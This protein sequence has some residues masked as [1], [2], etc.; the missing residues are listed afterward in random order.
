MRIKIYVLCIWVFAMPA[1][2]HAQNNSYQFSHLDITNGL[3]DNQVNCIYKDEKGFMW[4][5]TTSGLNRYDGSKFKVFKRDIKDPN[6]LA[7][8]HVMR[9]AEGPGKK[10]W[11]FTHSDISIY[12]PTVERF[13]NNIAA[14]LS[15]YKIPANPIT[16]I[17]KDKQGEFWFATDKKGLYRYS[18]KT[19]QTAFYNNSGNSPAALHSNH[20]IDIVASQPNC[21]WLI[22]NDG[23]IEQ[24]DSKVNKVLK[25]YD[26]LAKALDT[27][28]RNFIMIMD[29]KQNLWVCSD[30]G[31]IGVYCYKTL[32]NKLVHY[33]KDTPEGR[34][35]SNVITSIIQTDDDKIWVGSDH[36]GINVIDPITNKVYYILSRA[37]DAKS[38]SGNSVYLYKDNTG[39]IWAGTFKQGLNYYHRGIMQFPLYKHLTTDPKSLPCEDINSFE[40]DEKQNLWIGTNGNGLIYFNRSTN[41]YTQFKHD[42]SNPNSITSDIIVRL[43]IDK[44]KRLWIGTYFGGLD[45]YDGKT[46][47]HYRHNKKDPGSLTDDRIYTIME[48]A[49][50][51]L[52]VGTF[53]GGFNVFDPKTNSFRHP[54]Y[55]SN[56]E[57]T[58]VIYEDRQQNKW[59]GRDRGIDVILKGSN[60][61]RHYLSEPKNVNSLVGNDVNTITQDKKGLIWIGTKDGLS[62]LNTKTN[63]FLNIEEGVNLPANNVSNIIEDNAGRMWVSTTNGLASIILTEAEGK[64]KVE[65]SNYNELDGL[66]GRA[67]NL[68]AAKRLKSGELVFGG[69]HGFNLF[70]PMVLNTFKP[71]PSLVFTD[72]NLFNKSVAVGDTLNGKVILTKALSETKEITLQHNQNVFDI[73]FAAFDYF[74]PNKIKFE[75]KLEGFDKGWI[76]V[77]GN[78]RKATYTNLDGGDYTFKVR[79]QGT[80]NINKG[81]ISLNITVLPPFFKSTFAYI[82]YFVLLLSGLFYIRHRGIRKLKRRFESTQATIEAERKIAQEREEARR[83]HQLDLMKIKFFTNVSHEFRTPLSLIL[84]PIDSLIKTVDKAD[85]QSQLATIKRNGKRLLN[86]VNQLL[87]FRKMEYNELKLSLKQGDIIKFIKEVSASFM[88]VAHQKKI[89]FLIE[90]EVYSYVTNFDH[91]KI[92][93]ILFNLLSNAFKFTPSGRQISVMLNLYRCGINE[94]KNNLEIKVIDTGIGIATENQG[95]IFDRFFQ[96]DMPESLLNQGS[97]IG[98]S[99]TKEFVKM[100]G[101]SIELESELNYGSCFTVI[102]PVE[103]QCEKK[104]I[105]VIAETGA[106]ALVAVTSKMNPGL[107]GAGKKATILLIEDND[108]LRFYLKDNLKNSFH[109][110]EAVNGK[111]GWQK[112]LSMHPKLIVSDISMPE[113]NGIE[114]CKK[115]KSDARTAQIPVILLTALTTEEDQLAGL[116]S[117]AN[118][119]ILKPFNFEILLSKIHNSLQMHQTLKTTYQKQIE[120]KAEDIHVVSEDEKFLK[121]AFEHIEL[122]I[123]KINFSVEELSKQ[124]NLSRVSLYKKLLTLTGKTPVDCIRTVRLK[125][126]VQLLEKS[127]LSIANVA[128]EVG[129]NNPTYFSKVFKEEYGILPSEYVNQ[130]RKN[131]KEQ[132]ETAL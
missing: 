93:R 17:E 9:I 36:G 80:N 7:E 6:S 46:F 104:E 22:Y 116:D 127:Q 59:V 33:S 4:F 10:L 27:K 84:S 69:I 73:E 41:A 5:G 42:P 86:L 122:N 61:V 126:A 99:I 123:T 8:N 60:K 89:E 94:E 70:D 31:T 62:I 102:L 40:E 66:Q 43:Y 96:D 1:Y 105:E 107:P 3:S 111:D 21:L 13:S 28:P 20:V 25:R 82:S 44:K 52:W 65:I 124:L 81:E 50:G 68:Y 106:E 130:Y 125:R 120:V 57:Y 103:Q 51:E 79:T 76:T 119:Y 71:K 16:R 72:L 117:G 67:F 98:L 100:Q 26:G 85:Q 78:N 75:Y 12:D 83:M 37:D 54:K 55:S 97:G 35:N 101:G 77:T 92:E 128:Y 118:D 24:L 90:S 29:N 132:L 19:G 110:I 47:T 87:D 15:R 74:N 11:I 49:A 63:S 14:E 129:F 38:L 58:S 113:M 48:D 32:T 34:L 91:D 88:D 109:I 131:K 95:K 121:N 56:S 45:C 53:A 18:P 39:I 115:I 112:A 2:L 30:A 114:L 108:D 64:Y 23:I